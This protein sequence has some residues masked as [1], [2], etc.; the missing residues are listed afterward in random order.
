MANNTF[1]VVYEGP[2][3]EK[4]E[5]LKVLARK[6]RLNMARTT[7]GIGPSRVRDWRNSDPEFAEAYTVLVDAIDE[8]M[9]RK[10]KDAAAKEGRLMDFWDLERRALKPGY[11]S[12]H[13][14]KLRAEQELA[15]EGSADDS[16]IQ[17]SS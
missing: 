11:Y 9:F 1:P 12:Q 2:D 15:E 6:Q 14:I 17:L 5:F 13:G 10:Q 4:L 16:G 3:K 8:S 7:M